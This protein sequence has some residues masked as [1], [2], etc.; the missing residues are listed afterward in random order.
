[1]ILVRTFLP[2]PLGHGLVGRRI[3]DPHGYASLKS[4]ES[5]TELSINDD[6]NPVRDGCHLFEFIILVTRA[7]SGF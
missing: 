2:K 3:D 1:M 7:R 5:V 4:G 6:I